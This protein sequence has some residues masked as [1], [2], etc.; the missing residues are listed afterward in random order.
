M[1]FKSGGI[2]AGENLKQVG[3]VAMWCAMGK[4][5][6]ATEKPRVNG[7]IGG[8]YSPHTRVAMRMIGWLKVRHG[9]KLLRRRN[10]F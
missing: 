3:P 2:F 4:N 8:N 1:A 9:W 7:R 10:R 6:I 5:V